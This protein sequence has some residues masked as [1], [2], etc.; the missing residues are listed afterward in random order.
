MKREGCAMPSAEAA[1]WACAALVLYPYLLYPLLLALLARLFGRP[2]KRA[3]GIASISSGGSPGVCRHWPPG[4]SPIGLANAPARSPET[5]T[6][7]RSPHP[8]S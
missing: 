4:I 5:P 7:V 3:A 1:F 6:C 8:T 2:V